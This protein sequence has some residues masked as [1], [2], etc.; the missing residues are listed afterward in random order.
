[1]TT[2]LTCHAPFTGAN[3][4]MHQKKQISDCRCS[5][6]LRSQCDGTETRRQW[7]PDIPEDVGTKAPLT[8]EGIVSFYRYVITEK[9]KSRLAFCRAPCA[10]HV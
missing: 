10:T 3:L 8:R 4:Q 6:A 2:K 9:A 5:N 1:V 7:I